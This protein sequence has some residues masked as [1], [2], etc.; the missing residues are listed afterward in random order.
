MLTQA[1]AEQHVSKAESNHWMN[2]TRSIWYHPDSA[3]GFGPTVP[4]PPHCMRLAG[5]NC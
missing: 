4:L 1:L 5:V 3:D 2:E